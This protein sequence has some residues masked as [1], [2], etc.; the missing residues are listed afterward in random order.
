V[1]RALAVPGTAC[2]VDRPAVRRLPNFEHC[3]SH[4][5][6]DSFNISWTRSE[7]ETILRAPL[8]AM[9]AARQLT[10]QIDV[11]TRLKKTYDDL[12]KK[13]RKF[14]SEFN[15]Q[16]RIT[17]VLGIFFV[18]A[19]FLLIKKAKESYGAKKEIA[20]LRTK[21]KEFS[22]SPPEHEEFPIPQNPPLKETHIPI[23]Q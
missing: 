10:N 11:N 9:L 1:T 12:V 7:F 19:L 21:L 4:S 8:N 22:I 2:M 5:S 15:I 3:S 17:I 14:T 6:A 23:P 16:N 13:H 20:V 18:L